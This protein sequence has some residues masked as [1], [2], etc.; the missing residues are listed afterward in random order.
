MKKLL[1]LLANAAFAIQVLLLF[2]W[3]L[4]SFVSIPSWLQPIGRMHPL[5]LHFPIVLWILLA[6]LPL[7]KRHLV[8]ESYPPLQHLLLHLAVVMTSLTALMGFFLAQEGGYAGNTLQWHK[9]GG[10][11]L[12]FLGY[13]LLIGY[14]RLS[15]RPQLLQSIV[16]GGVFLLIVAS[17]FGAELTHGENFVFAPLQQATTQETIDP[18]QPIAQEMVLRI[19][20]SKCASCHN[21]R[22]KKGELDLSSLQALFA[23]GEHGDIIIAGNAKESALMQRLH[24]PLS[25]DDH[26]P[27]EGKPQLDQSELRLLSVWIDNGA[28]K[29]VQLSDL[30]DSSSLFAAVN[31]WISRQGIA[32]ADGPRYSFPAASARDIQELN[33]PFRRVSPIS[34]TSPAL[35][36]TIFVRKAYTPQSIADLR[37][38][39]QQLVSLNLSHLPVTDEDL[40]MVGEFE[41]LERVILNGTEVTHEGL[42][43]LTTCQHLKS[44]AVSSTKIGAEI[45]DL[46][47]QWPLLREVFVWNT[48]LDSVAINSLSSRFPEMTVERGY[49]PDAEEILNMSP[50]QIITDIRVLGPDDKVELKHNFPG[51]SI[52]YTTDGSE[53]DSLNGKLYEGPIKLDGYTQV[54]AMAFHQGWISSQTISQTFFK[55]GIEIQSAELEHIPNKRFMGRGAK[56]ILDGQKGDPSSQEGPLWIGYRFNP[57]SAIMDLGEDAPE[58]SHLT[59]S[60]LQKTGSYIMPPKSIEVWGGPEKD[61]LKRLVRKIPKQ[62]TESLPNEI[63]G[64]ELSFEPAQYRYLKVVAK[65]VNPM[66]SWHKGAGDKG[67]VFVDEII[68]Q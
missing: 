23:G 3:I 10:L 14:P 59:F 55:K 40:K 64:I 60:Y 26:M 57:F 61:Q 54:K 5:L 31:Q 43:H 36:A 41:K 17:H 22:K 65:P 46:L 1:S 9:W 13:G 25:D 47:P 52:H 32:T 33:T 15:E 30:A 63:L 7:A 50:P 45:A 18:S 51:V 44:L 12:S 62:P 38:V 29:T 68:V 28:S 49:I 67:W 58:I 39:K 11:L 21:S 2:L 35:E 20:D 34:A 66:P 6:V 37:S 19:L 8:S 56:T 4:E 16:G 42:Q 53:P 48:R 27:P 24:L